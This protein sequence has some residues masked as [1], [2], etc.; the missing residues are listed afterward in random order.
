MSLIRIEKDGV[1]LD[2]VKESLT[3]R[4]ENNALI[5]NFKVSSSSFPFLIVENKK[6]KVALGTRDVTSVNKTKTVTVDVYENDLKYYG[7]LEIV[8]YLKGYRKCNLKYASPLLAIMDKKIADFMP[9]ISVVTGDEILTSDFVEENPTVFSGDTAWPAYAESI[10]TQGF[11]AAKW[12]FPMMNWKDKFGEKLESDDPWIDFKNKVNFFLDDE[13]QI[14]TSEYIS[15]EVIEVHNKNVPM[16]QIYLLSPLFYALKSINF[17]YEGD[18]TEDAFIKKLMMLSFK[19]NLCKVLLKTV[20]TDVVFDGSWADILVGAWAYKRKR[21][22]FDITETGDYTIALNFVISALTVPDYKPFSVR[23]MVRRYE[24]HFGLGYIQTDNE[25]AFRKKTTH[26]GEIFEGEFNMTFNDTDKIYF[27]FECISATM[28]TSYT[29]NFRKANSDKDF[30]Q[31]HPTIPTGR[32]L[33][34][35]TLATYINNLKNFFNL[36]IDVDDLRN[37]FLLNFNEDWITNQKPEIIKKSMAITSYEQEAYQA[38]LLKYENDE[39]T[40]LWIT[41]TGPV[42]FTNQAIDTAEQLESKFK[43]IPS[44][45][46]TSNLSS[47]VEDKSGVGLIIYD[48]TAAPYTS[49][50]FDGKTLKIDGDGGI[51]D[52]FWKKWLKFRVN[53]SVIEIS[54]GFTK[55]EIGKFLKTKRIHVDHQDYVISLLDYKELKQDNYTVTFKVESV[56]I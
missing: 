24:N 33:P 5:R 50:T 34:D 22:I 10:I 51:Y 40:A 30:Y 13:Y 12:N 4:K 49:D 7:Q 15:D 46:G 43:F 26:A 36:N 44:A 37:K 2:F 42:T 38:F 19:N 17:N 32:Y 20:A 47:D 25:V 21:E 55:T 23:L 11:P 45:L 16:P 39:D 48:E 27:D 14:N 9:I 41:R 31:M 8:S 53:A 28:P 3:I 54:G 29:L 6:A 56:T 52:V 18:F 1:V 35:W